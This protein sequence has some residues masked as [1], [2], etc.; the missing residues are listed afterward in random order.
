MY[1][2]S[3]DFTNLEIFNGEHNLRLKVYEEGGKYTVRVAKR[4]LVSIV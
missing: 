3:A 1:C 4:S 2:G